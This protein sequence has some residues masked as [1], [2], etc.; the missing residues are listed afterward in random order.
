LY[1]LLG[2]N[3]PSTSHVENLNLAK[4]WGFKVSDAMRRCETLEDVFAFIRQWDEARKELPV[5]TDGIVIKVDSLIQQEVLG[6]TAKSP[7]WAIAYKFQAEQAL[8]RLN[9]ISFQVGRTGAVT[10]VANLDPVLLSGTTVKRASLHNNDIIQSLDLYIG[11][12]VY[13][14]KGGEIIPK[15]TGVD[16]SSR[17]LLGDKVTFI[18]HCP[19]CGTKLVRFEGEAAHYCPNQ[20]GCPPQI[21]A[22]LEHFIS[23]KAMNIEGLGAETVDALYEAGFLTDLY[24]F[25]QLNAHTLVNMERLG[26]KSARNILQGVRASKSVPFERVLFALGIRFVGETVA[27][28]LSKHFKSMEALQAATLEELLA[29]DEVGVK[30]AESVLAYFASPV[31]RELVENLLKAGLK[32]SVPEAEMT[33]ASTALEGKSIVISGTF[34]DYSRDEYKAMIEQHGGKNA[35]SISRNTSFILAGENMGPAKL[36]KAKALNIPLVT[37]SSFLALLPNTP[38][39]IDEHD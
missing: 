33:L 5:A 11:D 32:M 18:T 7:R 38:T 28:K 19:E 3:L 23:R 15:I 27:K 25:Y 10:P 13:V 24:S 21:K 20:T 17:F 30:I 31:N 2:K 4:S 37:E 14:E 34:T 39:T 9:A 16:T 1:Y 6:F 36:E 26:E 35:S 8:T 29:V 12:M 22:R